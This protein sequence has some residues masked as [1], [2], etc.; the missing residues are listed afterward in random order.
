MPLLAQAHVV[1]SA[2]TRIVGLGHIQLAIPCN[3]EEQARAFYADV[4]W[5]EELPKRQS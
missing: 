5:L 2:T 4:M 3:A 1:N